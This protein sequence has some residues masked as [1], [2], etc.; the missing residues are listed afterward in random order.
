MNHFTTTLNLYSLDAEYAKLFANLNR[1]EDGTYDVDEAEI[2]SIL[3]QRYAEEVDE[4]AQNV[5]SHINNLN[6][7]IKAYKDELERVK[8]RITK[9]LSVLTNEVNRFDPVLSH[10]LKVKGTKSVNYPNGSIKSRTSTSVSLPS[11]STDAYATIAALLP[12]R[13]VNTKTVTVRTIDKGMIKEAVKNND[14]TL[15]EKFRGLVVT[16]TNYKTV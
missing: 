12:E 13:F 2:R 14:E 7:E 10:I 6:A 5:I 3:E 11:S 8:E 15:P 4:L 9:R 1:S 16:K